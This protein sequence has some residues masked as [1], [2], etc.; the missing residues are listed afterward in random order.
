MGANPFTFVETFAEFDAISADPQVN[1]SGHIIGLGNPGGSGGHETVA[2]FDVH[3][4]NQLEVALRLRSGAYFVQDVSNI[5]LGNYIG[6]RIYIDESGANP[7]VTWYTNPGT[8]WAQVAQVTDTTTGTATSPTLMRVG[9]FTDVTDSPFAGT[10][11]ARLDDIILG[12]SP[13]P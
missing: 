1:H 9:V 2:Y 7:V 4:A 10:T 13:Q 5:S 6:L 8:G 11:I 12:T 3:K